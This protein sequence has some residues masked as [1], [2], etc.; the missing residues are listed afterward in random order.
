MKE[1]LLA[2]GGTVSALAASTCCILPLALVSAGISGAWVGNLA[3]LT[4]YQPYLIAFAVLCLGAGF[5][6]VYRRSAGDCASG[7]CDA[8]RGGRMIRNVLLAKGILWVG[9]TLVTLLVGVDYG[10]RL[11]R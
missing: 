4:P 10:V 9:A 11:F 6:L 3:A 8:P 2:A 5:R 1:T 7:D